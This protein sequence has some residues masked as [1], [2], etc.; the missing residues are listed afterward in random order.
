MF[1]YWAHRLT[2]YG[3]IIANWFCVF[4]GLYCCWN[5]SLQKYKQNK[6]NAGSSLLL[7]RDYRHRPLK[8]ALPRNGDYCVKNSFADF[9]A[10]TFHASLYRRK[11]QPWIVSAFSRM[12]QQSNSKCKSTSATMF[13][14]ATINITNGMKKRKTIL[15]LILSRKSQNIVICYNKIAEMRVENTINF[16][17]PFL[18]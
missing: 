4:V 12:T 14:G 1:N 3:F 15:T 16:R 11:Y 6:V 5:F 2:K 18:D 17:I 7:R 13:D 10:F 8:M 9:K